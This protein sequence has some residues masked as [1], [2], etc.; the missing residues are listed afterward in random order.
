M[1]VP[2]SPRH[3]VVTK[4][5]SHEMASQN[6]Y[7]VVDN[8]KEGRRPMTSTSRMCASVPMGSIVA[9]VAQSV[10]TNTVIVDNEK[11]SQQYRGCD[12]LKFSAG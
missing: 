2:A 9:Y 10:Q 4:T 5:Q 11:P 6:S 12:T 8:G 1:R 7:V 3:L